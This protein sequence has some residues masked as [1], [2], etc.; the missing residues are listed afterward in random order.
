[1]PI[2]RAG[3][4][5]GPTFDDSRSIELDP[6]ARR[7]LAQH[8]VDPGHVRIVVERVRVDGFVRG[9][10][11]ARCRSAAV[12]TRP[13]FAGEVAMARGP[14]QHDAVH[15]GE[16]PMRRQGVRQAVDEVGRGERVEPRFPP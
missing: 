12:E 5:T 16:L 1:M 11:A 13:E 10:E 3:V 8:G 7:C 9:K 14:G 2:R 15:P 4:E 6:K